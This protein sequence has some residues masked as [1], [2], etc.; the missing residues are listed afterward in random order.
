MNKKQLY[1]R[2]KSFNRRK[3]KKYM[4]NMIKRIKKQLK[5][6]ANKGKYSKS[7]HTH[8]DSNDFHDLNVVVLCWFVR[9]SKLK[10][11]VT[12]KEIDKLS[13]KRYIEAMSIKFEWG[14]SPSKK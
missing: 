5:I 9:Y 14:R 7:Y 4:I 2:A 12:N 11:K 8:V 13:S 6:A 3:E 1:R 10:P